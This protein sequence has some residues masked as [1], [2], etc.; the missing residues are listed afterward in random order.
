MRI[1]ALICLSLLACVAAH[2]QGATP[3]PVTPVS[4]L[5]VLTYH[6]VRDDV[7]SAGD[8]DGEATSTDRLIAHFDWLHAHGYHMVSLDDVIAA[9]HGQ[10]PLPDKAVLLTFDDGL[11]SFY[12]RVYPLLRAYRYP[13][14]SAL[15]GAWMDMPPGQTMEFNKAT[16]D[17]TC[18][19][20]WEQVHDMQASGLVEFASH[21]YD[22]HHG[23]P[24]NPQGNEM[25]AVVTLPYDKATG[26]YENETTYTARI[27]ADLRKSADE[28]ALRTGRRPRAIVWPYGA[29][30][31]VATDLARQEGM[32]ISL[33]LGDELATT[34][35]GQTI[36]RLLLSGN[37]G[38]TRFAW[39]IRHQARREPVRAVQVD[40]D[41]VYDP[42]PL[43]QERNL[44]RLLDR[45]KRMQPTQVW[46]QAY[47]DPDG[48]GLVKEVYFPNRHL[49][50]RADLFSRVAWQ[51]RTRAGVRVYAWLPLLSYRFPGGEQLPE[52]GNRAGGKDGDPFRLAPWDPK[53]RQL[54]GDVYEDLAKT[55]DEAGLLFS[56]DGF[57][58]DTD[59]L[60]PW[61]ATTPAQ[62]TARL[63]AFTRELSER[64]RR[65]RP[66]IRTVRN[67]Y[68]RPVLDPQA[69]AW[70]AQSLPAFI[71]AYDMTA[72]MAM[73]QLDKAAD[74]LSWYRKLVAAVGAQPDGFDRTL[75]ELATQDWQTHKPIPVDALNARIRLL[76]A[77]GVRHVGYYP[78]DF[79]GDH[80]GLEAIRPSISNAD[81]PY[82]EK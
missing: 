63:I 68:A 67:I 45:I 16:C 6:D 76:Q 46:L 20:S 21:T 3:M 53:V 47:A 35:P 49:P 12:T 72:L 32:E 13:A 57:I 79:I 24:G 41:Y 28:I 58:R 54:I 33:S 71:A 19:L 30:N 29:F 36:S 77:A 4:D 42:D 82:E 37:V 26:T 1:F 50:M 18:F 39:L 62:R 40:L 78:D 22:L 9:R 52:L 55:T 70:F 74:T 69:E 66:Q 2:A 8:R 48:D 27:R 59:H 44:S 56:D 34:A 81:F 10:R 43:Q 31:R 7:A 64:V 11:E 5:I 38:V 60:G 61:A 80:P 17:H 75:F 65:W 14:L 51:L 73:P 15:V 23:I 25:P